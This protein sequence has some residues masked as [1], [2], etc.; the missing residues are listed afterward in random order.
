MKT[1]IIEQSE[2]SK[3][4]KFIRTG[5][6]VVF[7]TETVYGIGANAYN[8]DAVRMIF[9]VKRRPITNPLIV[10]VESI[11]K[12]NELVEHIPKSALILMQRFTPGPITFILKNAGKISNFISGGL[13]SIAVRI[14][15][16]P[17]AIQLIKMSGVPIAAPS[18]NLSRRPSS[19]NFKMAISELDGLVKG[20]I[21]KDGE[22][23][24]GIESTVIRFDLKGNISILRP[25]LIT[26]EMIEKELKGEFKVEY[27]TGKEMLSKSPGNLLEHYRP[28]IPVY[29]F[30]K[31]DNI[32]QYALRKDT[33]VLIMRDTLNSYWFNSFWNMNN[34][35]VFNTLEEYAKNIYKVFVESEKEY[36]QIIA[37][38]VDDSQL[39]YSI[40]NRLKKASLN[41]FIS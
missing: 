5:E 34:I 40:N 4:A 23:K 22:S 11:E 26:K 3:A 41:K 7:P 25:G 30:K 12:I 37:E 33:K 14:P 19:T 28:R 31:T 18:A 29:L 10:H 8:D 1:E 21:K 6:L 32:K 36:N 17:V 24:I 35:C 39:G 27:S 9:L 38:L 2:I 20:I 13:D 16:E 15:S